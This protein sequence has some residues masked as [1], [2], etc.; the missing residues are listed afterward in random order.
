MNVVEQSFT[1]VLVA[2]VRL[3]DKMPSESHDVHPSGASI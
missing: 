1:R 2:V 3:V